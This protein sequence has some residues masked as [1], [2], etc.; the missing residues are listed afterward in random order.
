MIDHGVESGEFREVDSS[1]YAWLLLSTLEGANLL[2]ISST[3][4]AEA[5]EAA[6]MEFVTSLKKQLL[7][8]SASSPS[9][10]VRLREFLLLLE[11]SKGVF[12]FHHPHK[13]G[14]Y[15]VTN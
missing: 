10:D 7:V 13:R 11:Q 15:R 12:A 8:R 2:C 5:Q 3:V 4:L 9:A 6:A 14:I 1:K